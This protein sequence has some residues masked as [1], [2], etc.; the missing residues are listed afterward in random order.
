M[1][2]KGL[3][4]LFKTIY[5]RL[6]GLFVVDFVGRIVSVYGMFKELF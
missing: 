5:G 2:V 1:A 3:F 4:R 6:Y